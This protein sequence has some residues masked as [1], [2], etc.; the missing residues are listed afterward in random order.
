MKMKKSTRDNTAPPNTKKTTKKK[1][2][3]TA[4]GDEVK[5]THVLPFFASFFF[6]LELF[7]SL[8]L[9][10]TPIERTCAKASASA[11]TASQGPPN[12]V[13]TW[14]NTPASNTAT[15]VAARTW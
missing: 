6:S 4:H 11:N 3:K 15:P 12:S 14:L 1:K 7:P 2:T 5:K 8:N 13:K 9:R 10:V